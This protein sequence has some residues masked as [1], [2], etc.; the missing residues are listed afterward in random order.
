MPKCVSRTLV[1]GAALCTVL[2][3][4]PASAQS[5]LS[6]VWNNL[7][8]LNEDW[9]DRAPGPERG[10]YA[11]LPRTTPCV[12]RLGRLA[13]HAGI[14]IRVP[15][16]LRV[17]FRQ[18]SH[19]GRRDSASQQLVAIFR[20]AWG[21][22]AIWMDAVIAKMRHARRWA[23]AG[24]WDEHPRRRDAARRRGGRG[25][26]APRSDSAPALGVSSSHLRRGISVVVEVPGGSVA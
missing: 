9:P 5:N 24:K 19:L 11:G 23:S 13:H 7:G 16:G 18:S 20:F 8:I 22:G 1:A 4:I 12:R 14:S 25:A 26:A 3:S 2:S 15:V 10:D 6:G 17:E 21:T